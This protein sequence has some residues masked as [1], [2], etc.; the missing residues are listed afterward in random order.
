MSSVADTTSAMVILQTAFGASSLVGKGVTYLDDAG[1]EQTGTVSSVRFENNGV[2]LHIGD[3]EVALSAVVS[4][5]D[6]GT[7]PSSPPS[8]DPSTTPDPAASS[9]G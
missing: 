2:V 3:D 9:T 1:N 5:A 6:A 7:L 4:V 8:S